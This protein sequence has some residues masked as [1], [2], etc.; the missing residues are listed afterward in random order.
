MVHTLDIPPRVKPD[1]DNGYFEQIVK[2]MFKVGFSFQVV[3]SIWE[4]FRGV[5]DQFDFKKL[6]LWSEDRIIAAASNPKVI[7]NLAKIRAVIHN[8]NVF[9]EILRDY[10]TFESFLDS[11]RDL[12]YDD[13]SKILAKRF[14]WVGKTAVFVFL[15]SVAEPVPDWEQ[16]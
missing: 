2:A 15:Y 13:R 3:N 11:N 9:L 8:A 6:A 10:P 12:Q 4:G 16:R 1:D 7:R 14:K 5:F